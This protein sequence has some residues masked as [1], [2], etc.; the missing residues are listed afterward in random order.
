MSQKIHGLILTMVLGCF[1]AQANAASLAVGTVRSSN[2]AA[3]YRAD[4]VV[5]AVR[6]TVIS[7]QVSGAVT[8]LPVRAGDAIKAGATLLR[9]DARAANQ[10]VKAGNAQAEAARAGLVLAAR[11]YE[12]Q[13]LLFAKKYISQAQLDQ[14]ES[15]FKA[16]TAQANAQIAQAGAIQ[17]Q[18]GFFLLKA[19][20]TGLISE[21]AV[22]LGD[23]AMPGRPLMTVYDPSAM[24]VTA[25]V[26]QA[27]IAGLQSGQAV[28]IEFAGLPEAQRWVTASKVTILP[29]A[30]AA[31]HTV[32]VRLDLPAS[33][34]GLTPGMFARASLPVGTAGTAEPS[35]L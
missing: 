2:E 20:Y 34:T 29:V 9:I 31:T 8:E 11:D 19:P 3:I 18:S 23:M 12:R 21:V 28:R 26:P 13:K 4:G 32:Q 15:Q 25:T 7:A 24:R 6:Q 16:S 27:R 35:R 22:T 14:A 33:V 1:A 30:D 17:T 10:E 5:E